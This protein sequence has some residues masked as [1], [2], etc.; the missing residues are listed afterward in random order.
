MHNVLRL[1]DIADRKGKNRV[2]LMF[3][4]SEIVGPAAVQEEIL[5]ANPD[6]V[7]ARDIQLLP[8]S[9]DDL[10][11]E[12]REHYE[13]AEGSFTLVLIGKDGE[14]KFRSAHPVSVEQLCR[15]IDDLP[16]HHRAEA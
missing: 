3:C 15:I 6:A 9:H 8:V 2:L 16:Q 13:V 10:A 4:P 7:A 12:I 14:V 5:A 1:Q 11:D